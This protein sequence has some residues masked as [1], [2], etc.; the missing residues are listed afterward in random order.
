MAESIFKVNPER[1]LWCCG[2]VVIIIAQHHS[3]NPELIFCTV[4]NSACS[5]SEI[6]E[7]L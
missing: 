4:P 7:N 5:M 6:H 2:V 3:A 1:P